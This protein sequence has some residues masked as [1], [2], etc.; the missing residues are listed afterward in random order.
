MEGGTVVG[1]DVEVVEVVLVDVVVVGA[2]LLLWFEVSE[3]DHR[4][5]RANGNQATS[6]VS[7][8]WCRVIDASE[9]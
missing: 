1:A 9:M 8:R 4:C 5:D 3:V 2:A 7:I 6:A